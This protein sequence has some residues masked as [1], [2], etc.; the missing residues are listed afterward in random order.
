MEMLNTHPATALQAKAF[1]SP[2]SLSFP[3]GAAQLTPPPS[4]P[5]TSRNSSNYQRSN[6]ASSNRA[7]D[8]NG[9]RA[10]LAN[11]HS[12][13]TPAETPGPGPTVSGIVP[14]LQ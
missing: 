7:A 3:G 5:E 6:M 4:E 8:S 1:T 11:G 14:T 10:E 13:V 9:Q 2:S 12:A